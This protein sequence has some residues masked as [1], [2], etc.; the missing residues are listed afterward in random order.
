MVCELEIDEFE[1]EYCIWVGD[2]ESVFSELFICLE[3]VL[4]MD[5]ILLIKGEKF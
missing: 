5:F 4:D 1:V 3:K 2:K